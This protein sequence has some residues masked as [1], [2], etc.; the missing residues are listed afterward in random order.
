MGRVTMDTE[1]QEVT[2]C[3]SESAAFGVDPASVW[4][5]QLTSARC[6]RRRGQIDYQHALRGV[7]CC[8]YDC[9]MSQLA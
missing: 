5:A 3:A 2:C 4:R 1:E 8:G 7:Q 9:I 6:T